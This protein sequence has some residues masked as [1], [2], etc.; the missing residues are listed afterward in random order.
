[1]VGAGIGVA[2]GTRSDMCAGSRTTWGVGSAMTAA[3][4]GIAMVFIIAGA[5]TGMDPSSA[6][7]RRR[8]VMRA[9][10]SAEGT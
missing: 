5:D 9:M 3:I 1:M 6:S 7:R 8:S 4:A 2:G 10:S